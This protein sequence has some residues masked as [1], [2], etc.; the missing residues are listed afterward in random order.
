MSTLAIIVGLVLIVVA[1]A[2]LMNTL[3]TTSTSPW[4]WWPSRLVGYR[5]FDVLRL[6]TAR[7]REDSWLR[8][9]LLSLFAPLLVLTLL[10][11]W[12]TM[13]IVGFGCIWWA[14]GGIQGASTFLDAVYYSGVVYFTLGFGEVLPS[15]GLARFG[16]LAEAFA[17]V[18]TSALVI[19]YLPSLY[20]AYSRT[21][22]E[23]DDT[24]RWFR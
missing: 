11:M 23:V 19:G 13:Q 7:M 16:A 10:A 12:A 1:L 4:R 17:G 18:T 24:R 15:D 21:R 14:V 20:G 9:R 3:V 8:E 2:D 6:V 5:A 22:T